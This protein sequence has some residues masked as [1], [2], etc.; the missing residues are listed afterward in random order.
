M[1]TH[2]YETDRESYALLSSGR[3]LYGYPGRAAFPARLASEVFSRCAARLAA[4]RVDGP[5][6]VYDP[7]CGT[8]IHLATMA[9][10]T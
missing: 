8:A 7:C 9:F 3:V 2:E 6:V 4:E 5:Y 1:P 10:L